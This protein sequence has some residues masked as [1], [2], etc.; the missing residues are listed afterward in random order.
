MDSTVEDTWTMLWS[1]DVKVVIMLT[2]CVELGKV[3][4]HNTH[5]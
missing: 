2:N 3:N 5:M 1:E 4:T